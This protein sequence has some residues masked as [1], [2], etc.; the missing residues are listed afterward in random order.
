MHD[1]A[2][3]RR[4]ESQPPVRACEG[5]RLAMIFQ[6]DNSAPANSSQMS[7]WLKNLSGLNSS[8]LQ[9]MSV[10]RKEIA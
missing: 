7:G 5:K 9:R 1:L 3:E 6:I 4:M 8:C 2:N 10:A